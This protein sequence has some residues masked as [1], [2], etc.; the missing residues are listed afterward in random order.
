VS[1]RDRFEI[2]VAIRSELQAKNVQIDVDMLD[3]ATRE[4]EQRLYERSLDRQF[5]R[6]QER[7]QAAFDQQVEDEERFLRD[8]FS[9]ESDTPLGQQIEGE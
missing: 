8:R 4:V 2:L 6:E 5:A 7:R 3:W 9:Y 1:H